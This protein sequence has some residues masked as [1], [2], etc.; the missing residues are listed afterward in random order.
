MST[1]IVMYKGDK[2]IPYYK[3]VKEDVSLHDR[4]A[5]KDKLPEILGKALARSWID[6]D[7]NNELRESVK[8][9]LALG[10][11]KIPEEYEC[12]YEKTNG[13]RAKIIVYEKIRNNLKIRVCG[14]SLTMVATR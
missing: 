13:Q 1:A 4:Q 3:L 10:G 9:T 7:Y 8:E 11:V 14:L 6:E 2:I 12:I 5:V